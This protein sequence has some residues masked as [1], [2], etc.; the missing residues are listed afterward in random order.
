MS[1]PGI[2][3]M[4]KIVSNG[5]DCTEEEARDVFFNLYISAHRIASLL[6]NELPTTDFS[7]VGWGF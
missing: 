1:D 2:E 5:F 4:L 3:E 7:G 6:A